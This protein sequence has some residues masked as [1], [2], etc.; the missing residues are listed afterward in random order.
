MEDM[1]AKCPGCLE[2]IKIGDGRNYDQHLK[3]CRGKQECP[4]CKKRFQTRYLPK[5]LK[6]CSSLH[7]KRLRKKRRAYQLSATT[8]FGC[9]GTP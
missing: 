8:T 6:I 9:A 3:R 7:G 4:G 2:P 1:T 5:H